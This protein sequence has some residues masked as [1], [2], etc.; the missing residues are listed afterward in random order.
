MELYQVAVCA[1]HVERSQCQLL[2]A[3]IANRFLERM[4]SLGFG[5]LVAQYVQFHS[6]S[7]VVYN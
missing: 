2:S 6:K 5:Q 7:N 4:A 3:L 1:A